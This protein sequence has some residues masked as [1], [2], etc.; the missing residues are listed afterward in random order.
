MTPA[1]STYHHGDLRA[2]LVQTA[3][4]LARADGPDGVVLRETARRV[5]VSHN[6]A[7]R[8]F[9]DREELLGEVAEVAMQQL[10]GAMSAELDTVTETEPVARALARMRATGRAYV[11]FALAQPG[12]FQVA[13]AARTAVLGEDEPAHAL[14]P[15]ADPYALLGLVLDDLVLVGGV[16]PERR[17]GAEALCWSAVHGFAVLHLNGPLR[18]VPAPEREESL[19]Q[20]LDQIQRGLF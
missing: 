18:D 4:E 1:G 10:A 16:T 6:A 17:E 15:D 5:G 20:L 3:T 12:L 13:F 9:A 19:E 8:H 7:Y 2:A 14:P 11:H